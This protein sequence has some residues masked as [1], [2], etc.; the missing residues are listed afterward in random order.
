MRPKGD[1]KHALALEEATRYLEKWLKNGLA[2]AWAR[3]GKTEQ[4]EIH[5][6]GSD[7]DLRCLLAERRSVIIAWIPEQ[8]RSALP[9][10]LPP[11]RR[12]SVGGG[13]FSGSSSGCVPAYALVQT[14]LGATPA[15][16]IHEGDQITSLLFGNPPRL[17]T[18]RVMQVH[19]SRASECV[20]LNESFLFTASQRYIS[21]GEG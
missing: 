20:L 13:S 3:E 4:L 9:K 14:P 11:K 2:G 7:T 5:R 16:C 19:A 1:E 17:V 21:K 15:A 6:M 18:T 12:S 8:F 10:K